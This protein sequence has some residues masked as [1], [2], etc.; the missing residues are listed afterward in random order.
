[1]QNGDICK[2]SKA[3]QEWDTELLFRDIEARHK[4][5]TASEQRNLKALLLGI[6]PKDASLTLVFAEKSI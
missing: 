2:F 3:E 6:S 5:L 4:K 1:M